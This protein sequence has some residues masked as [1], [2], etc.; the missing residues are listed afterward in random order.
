MRGDYWVEADGE[1]IH[2]RQNKGARSSLTP[3][4]SGGQ[5]RAERLSAMRQWAGLF[6]EG[7]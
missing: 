5:D 7:T 4:A 3:Q 1:K 6:K 2:V